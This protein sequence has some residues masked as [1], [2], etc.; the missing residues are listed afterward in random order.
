MIAA[1]CSGGTS[2]DISGNAI[3]PRPK[4]PPL[5]RPSRIT[6]TVARR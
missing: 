2:S 5:D 1:A 3:T 4:K 6:A